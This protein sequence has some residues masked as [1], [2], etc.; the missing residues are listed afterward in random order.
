MAATRYSHPTIGAYYDRFGAHVGVGRLASIAKIA[1]V[2][3]QEIRRC[4]ILL[5]NWW[6]D[7]L[8]DEIRAKYVSALRVDPKLHKFVHGMLNIDP[9][10]ALLMGCGFSLQVLEIYSF[11]RSV[12]RL[13]RPTIVVE[14][15]VSAGVTTTA[16]LMALADSSRGGYLYS[17]DL[18]NRDPA[19]YV[20]SDGA[21]DGVYTPA[22]LEQGWLVPD[23]LKANWSVQLGSSKEL[24][25]PLLDKLGSIDVFVHDSDHSSENMSFEF[26]KAWPMITKNGI[27]Y[28]DDIDWNVAWAVFARSIEPTRGIASRT[29]ASRGA[30]RKLD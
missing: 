17:I 29:P 4:R 12:E 14:T 24:L 10:D 27:L 1:D 22:A 8:A 30:I 21:A 2:R 16:I 18:P 19:G 26:S 6:E 20:N 13:D 15:G 25:P 5:Q 28:S 23:S 11:V 3:T 9:Q 7:G